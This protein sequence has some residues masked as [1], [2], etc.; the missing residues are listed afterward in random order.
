MDEVAKPIIE[1][2]NKMLNVNANANALNAL[3]APYPVLP[4]APPDGL[5]T[6]RH[7]YSLQKISEIQKEIENERQK[8]NQLSKKY[9]RAVKIISTIGSVMLG[10]TI[11]LGAIG[12]GF[13][14][15]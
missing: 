11:T 4:T 1:N 10:G 7:V 6:S 3:N 14:T 15:Q 8:R 5:V 9:H 2:N 12:I 13:L